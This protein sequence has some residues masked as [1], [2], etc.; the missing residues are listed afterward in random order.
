MKRRVLIT[1][2]MGFV[3]GRLAQHL[4]QVGYQIFLG[5]RSGQSP[6]QWL[7]NAEVVKM[8][9]ND[10]C[11]LSAACAGV[12]LIIHGAG[13]NAHDCLMNPLEALSFNGIATARLLD[14]GSK[15]GVKRFIYLS[16]AHVYGSSL[17]GV[18]TENTCPVSLHPYATSHRAGEDVVRSAHQ[19]G[20][21]E[22]VVIRLS[23]A[24]GA[25]ACKSA[26]CWML[27]VN[28]LCRQAVVSHDLVL[29]S[30][31]LERRDFIPLSD[32]CSA[33]EHLLDLPAQNLGNGLFNVGGGWSPTVWEIACFIQQRCMVKLG[34]EPTITRNPSKAGSV[35]SELD[36]RMDA[37]RESGFRLYTS[38]ASEIDR[39]LNF[40]QVAYA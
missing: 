17:V 3:G 10:S 9:W 35:R 40:C 22:G 5:S 33:I 32:V 2:G 18:V 26:N 30:S 24:Y 7:P 31:G 28:D 37:I 6:P 25:P 14:A 20:E 23:N 39:L 13:M 38:P 34:F 8:V 1:G 4:H 15:V 12:D 27:L 16:T 36:Y 11:E 19:R 21:I 29:R